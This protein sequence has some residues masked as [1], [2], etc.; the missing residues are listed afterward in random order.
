MRWAGRAGLSRPPPVTGRRRAFAVRCGDLLVN[1]DDTRARAAL[2]VLPELG[3]NM[4]ALLL[5]HRRHLVEIARATLGE[6]GNVITLGDGGVASARKGRPS[7]VSVGWH[8]TFRTVFRRACA[9]H[10]PLKL[11]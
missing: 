8:V 7:N 10:V 9:S 3:R 11:Y 2:R 4:Q 6:R 5:S 1:F